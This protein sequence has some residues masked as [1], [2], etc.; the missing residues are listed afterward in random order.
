M[1][2]SKESTFVGPHSIRLSPRN[3]EGI[4]KRLKAEER[5]VEDLFVEKVLL[6]LLGNAGRE[7]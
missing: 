1:Q 5:K 3:L 7:L 6:T 2:Q 4:L